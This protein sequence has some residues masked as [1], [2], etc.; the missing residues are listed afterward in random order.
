MS[1]AP[2]A[3]VLFDLDGTLLDSFEGL[4]R[5]YAHA[6]TTLGLPEP[7]ESDLR[8]CI[9]PPLRRNLARLLGTDDAATVERAVGVFRARYDAVG[10]AE[11]RLY[12][13]VLAMLEAVRALGVAVL[14][15]TAKP[16]TFTDRIVAHY[17]LDAHLDGAF[18]PTLDGSLDD[19]RRLLAHVRERTGFRPEAAAM[20]GDREN[21][22][23]AALAHGVLPVGVL[24]GYG[25]ADELT[26]AGA[27]HLCA[28][29]EDVVARLV[30]LRG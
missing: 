11:S 13:G 14:V 25:S 10:W 23:V 6:V 7:A 2:L 15:A 29:P 26:S 16:Q 27:A 19:K 12:D 22:V 18:G 28:R 8:P 9:G 24:W 30:A 21:D 4:A 17:G 3:T 5:C 1:R 20:V